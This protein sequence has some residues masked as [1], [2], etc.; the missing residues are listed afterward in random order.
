MQV[1][2]YNVETLVKGN[3]KVSWQYIYVILSFQH[4]QS[5]EKVFIRLQ[6]VHI[7]R[8]DCEV[9]GRLHDL[10][11]V[12]YIDTYITKVVALQFQV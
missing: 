7:S 4:L 3:L 10:Q 9:E 6:P 1:F 8:L 11:N 2:S 5:L 12:Q